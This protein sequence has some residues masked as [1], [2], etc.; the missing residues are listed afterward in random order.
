M[1]P[2]GPRHA[3]AFV[4]SLDCDVLFIDAAPDNHAATRISCLEEPIRLQWHTIRYPTR[5]SRPF[6]W[7][8][9]R[10]IQRLGDGLWARFGIA[11]STTLNQYLWGLEQTIVSFRP[12]IVMCHNIDTLSP[13]CRAAERCHA[14]LIFDSMEFYSEMG[15][16]QD[17]YQS[18]LIREIERACL[19]KCALITTSSHRMAEA[20]RKTYGVKNTLPLYNTPQCV[21]YLPERKES[22]FSLYWRNS[23]IGLGQRG[24]S[25]AIRALSLSPTD[26]TLH[27]QGRLPR[28][29]GQTIRA[30]AKS[31]NVSNRLVVHPPFKPEMAIQQAARFHVGLCLE[32]RGV[33][34]H[35][36]TVSNK[37]FDY[38]MAGLAVIASDL[39]PLRDVIERSGGG[40]LYTPGSAESLASQILAIYQDPGLY[41]GLVRH[42]REFA[43]RE[44]NLQTDMMRFARAIQILCRTQQDNGLEAETGDMATG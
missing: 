34:N 16:E 21:E 11:S 32:Q 6:R 23:T 43:L 35:E 33:R 36:L 28:D 42:A 37:L 1:E 41:A 40:L 39:P 30:L 17:E 19:P 29:G 10:I 3:R 38:H 31:L 2:R 24:L 25:D 8:L 27:V 44:G 18:K 20:L 4:D 13:A 12:D 9:A 15:E 7:A 26:V 22:G 5:E 14:K